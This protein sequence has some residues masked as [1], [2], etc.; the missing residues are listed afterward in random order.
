MPVLNFNEKNPIST[1]EGKWRLAAQRFKLPELEKKAGFFLIAPTAA[2]TDY[3][4]HPSA[5]KAGIS[6]QGDM[7]I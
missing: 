1:L 7:R 5:C 3:D 6:P 2:T 4:N